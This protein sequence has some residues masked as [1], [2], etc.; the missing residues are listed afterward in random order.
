MTPAGEVYA[1]RAEPVRR[2]RLGRWGAAV[3][4]L[5]SA[6]IG[7][8]DDPTSAGDVVVRRRG[9]G[10]EVLRVPGGPAEELAWTLQS[11]REQLEHLSVADF[12]DRWG[13][14]D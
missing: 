2:G 1:A 7:G 8:T 6:S 11:V 12:S 9:D 14:D 4:R 5:A 13:L 10:S 3:A